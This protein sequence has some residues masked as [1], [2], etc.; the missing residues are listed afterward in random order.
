[1]ADES[2]ATRDKLHEA[3]Q[4]A[5][6]EITRPGSLLTGWVLICEWMD[7]EGERWLSKGHC[8]STAP[9]QAE[10]MLHRGLYGDWPDPDE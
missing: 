5:G 3:I 1:M 4:E 9:W 7:D 6:P 2:D 8:A 10:G